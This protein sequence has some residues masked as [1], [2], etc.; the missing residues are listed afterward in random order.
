MRIEN[1][2]LY[3][4]QLAHLFFCERRERVAIARAVDGDAGDAVE[5]VK[6]YFL[7]FLD[8]FPV[9]HSLEVFLVVEFFV[10]G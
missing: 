6:E 8:G 5:L 3:A 4:F 10:N 7:V 2:N 9:S 1:R